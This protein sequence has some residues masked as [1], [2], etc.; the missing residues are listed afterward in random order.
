MDLAGAK[1]EK[2]GKIPGWVL[3][4]CHK[5]HTVHNKARR[6]SQPFVG[7]RLE[8]GTSSPWGSCVWRDNDRDSSICLSEIGS[9]QGDACFGQCN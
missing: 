5:D 6:R 2:S 7:D 9:L 8:P 1:K 4:V 3:V